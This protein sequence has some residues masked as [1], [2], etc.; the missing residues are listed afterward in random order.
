VSVRDRLFTLVRSLFATPRGSP[1][2]SAAR[3]ARVRD[4]LDAAIE[5]APGERR[6]FL[7]DACGDD[8][9][10]RREVESLLAAHESSGPVDRL[11]K[12]VP[13]AWRDPTPG[14]GTAVRHYRVGDR[15]GGGGMGVV[16]LAHDTRL[17]RTVALKFLPAHLGLDDVAKQRFLL[18]AQAAASLDHPNICT[19]HE[20]GEAADGMLYIVMPYYRGTPLSSRLLG[21]PMG[22]DEALEIAL[23]TARGLARAHEGGIVHRDIKP[24]NLM[25][26]AEGVVK[27]LDFGI[28]KVG[29]VSLTDAGHVVG[30]VAYMSPEQAAGGKVDHRTDLWSLGVVLHEM[31]AGHPPFEGDQADAVI[32]EILTGQPKPP[33]GSGPGAAAANRVVARLLAKDPGDRYG[34]ATAL[35]PALEDAAALS[36]GEPAPWGTAE[37]RAAPE[38]IAPEGERRQASVVVSRL[39]GYSSLL[40]RVPPEE[41]EQRLAHVEETVRGVIARHDGVVNQVG[42]GEF[43]CLFGVPTTHEDDCVRA[44]RAALELQRRLGEPSATGAGGDEPPIE[45]QAGVA[46]GL[47]VVQPARHGARVYAVAGHPL[48]LASLLASHA[49]A[50]EI[51]LMPECRR[52]VAPFF[53]TEPARPLV[54][55]DRAEALAPHRVVR[56]SGVT[57]RLEAA[58]RSGLT[59]FSGRDREIAALA[60]RLEAA[61]EGHGQLVT[62]VGDAGV[63]KSRLLQ[64]FAQSLG[65]HNARVIRGRCSSHSATLPYHPLIE[66]LRDACD[67]GTAAAT[68]LDGNAVA[69]KILGMRPELGD[70]MPLYLDLLSAPSERYPLPRHLQGEHLRQAI[71][72]SLSALFTGG[73]GQQ[74]VALVLEDWH[75]A[76]DASHEAL[77]HL[78]AITPEYRLLVVVTYRPGHGVT[79]AESSRPAPIHLGPL[80]AAASAR[81]VQSVLRADVVPKD[82]ALAIHERSGGNP[83]FLEELCHTLVEQRLLTVTSGRAA[84]SGSVSELHLPGTIEGVIRTR[85]D[86]LD[87][88]ARE[89]IRVASVAGREFSVSVLD[90]VLGAQLSL[91][92]AVAR[93]KELGLVQQFRVVPE[94]FYRFKHVLT[95]EVAYETL[96]QHQRRGLHGRVGEAIEAVYRGRAEEHAERLADHFS[97]A[98]HWPKAVQYGRQAARKAHGLSEFARA[99]AIL[100]RVEAWILRLRGG[101]ERD[102]SLAEVLFQQERLC[103]TLGHRARQQ[104]IITRLVSLLEPRGSSARLAEVYRRQGDLYTL[105]KRFDDAEEVLLRALALTADLDNAVGQRNTLTSLGLQRWHGG[106]PREG[107]RYMERALAIDRA[108]GE[109]DEIAHDLHNLAAILRDLGEY[110]RALAILEEALALAEETGNPLTSGFVLSNMGLLYR[111]MG[112]PERALDYLHRANEINRAHQIAVERP[113]LITAIAHLRLEQG[114]IDESVGLYRQAIGIARRT[115]NADALAPSLNILGEVLTGLNQPIDALPC[116][117]EAAALFGQL[118]NREAELR[119][120]IKAAEIHERLGRHEAA[121]ANWARARELS[122]GLGDVRSAVGALAGLARAARDGRADLE[123]AQASLDEALGL[124]AQLTD[125]AEEARLRNAAGIVAWCRGAYPQALA[126]YERALALCRERDDGAGV[127][128]ALNSLGL[129]LVRLGRRDEGRTRL[130]EAAAF[131]RAA[132]DHL[133][134]A[135]S[136]A[137]LGDLHLDDGHLAEAERCYRYARQLRGGIGDRRGEGWMLERLG[138]LAEARADGGR[139]SR[140]FE[141]ARDI[142]GQVADQELLRACGSPAE[143]L[144]RPSR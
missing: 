56:A 131:N 19:I 46:A 113:F 35:I 75:W 133:L 44:V 117:E 124:V 79:W 30:T 16:H 69:S 72:E 128:L 112:D 3:W 10:L 129:T 76:D 38:G 52:L 20:I 142:A 60:A 54:L 114:H 92:P 39:A 33:A 17:D 47:C 94:P 41:L 49:M 136:L 141:Q 64:E 122:H 55:P 7:V 125:G 88:E 37:A 70:F 116:L 130:E 62:V 68:P 2:L 144:G 59:A 8:G 139:A 90:R 99:L 6:T 34:A 14:P 140:F 102:D 36:R 40:E 81:V 120:R 48:D 123:A 32:A 5:R 13:T 115:R 126:H 119:M 26:T 111:R 105:V 97:R 80:D 95:Q 121:E 110:E 53:E 78:V 82:V 96:L 43:V 29:D 66:A 18:E 91:A 23:Q 61:I 27:V 1:P 58:T 28:A 74:P 127:G 11:G 24:A 100:D 22:L 109:K 12:D 103:E 106:R 51:L 107:L 67:L 118:E 108:R 138:R 98:E 87:A 65:E 25:I 101:T 104:T 73:A 89:V 93:L 45:V 134:E 4:L 50:G 71:H 15:V 143:Q 85:L 57:T 86:R 83:F 21:G 132:G 63:G 137:A 84:L 135:H 31:I 9:A 77:E 42:E